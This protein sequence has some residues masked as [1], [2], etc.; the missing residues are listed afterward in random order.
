MRFFSLLLAL[1]LSL[2]PLGALPLAAGPCILPVAGEEPMSEVER[3]QPYRLASNPITLPGYDGLLLRPYNRPEKLHFYEIAGTTYQARARPA[4]GS[5]IIDKDIR[6]VTG[7]DHFLAG[8][9]GRVLWQLPAGSDQWQEARP[10]EKWWGTAYD[11][12]TGDFYVGFAAQA[13]LLRWNGDAFVPTGPMPTASGAV[14]SPLTEFGL[15][16]AILTLPQ[17]GGTFA[18]AVDWHDEDRRSLWFRPLGGTWTLVATQQDLNRLTPGLRFPGP[19]RD[20]DVSEDGQTVRLFSNHQKDASVLLRHGPDGWTL[21]EAAPY[22]GWVKHRGSGI[23]LAWSGELSQDL[24]ERVLLFFER[25]VPFKP[26]VLQAL[27]PGT[28]VPRPVTEVTPK[29]DV[30]EKT[31]LNRSSIV[32]VP[33]V[34]PLLVEAETGWMAFEGKG[35]RTLPGWE[36][37][38]I[39]ENARISRVGPLVLIQS[40]N[41]VFRVTDTLDA[42]LVQTFPEGTSL[43]ATTSITWLEEA[44]LFVVMAA[45][46][47]AV[48]TSRDF[49]SFDRVPSPVPITSAVAALPDRPGMLLVG[50][51]GLYTLEAECPRGG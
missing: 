32:E 50:T 43:S 23:R 15:P 19:F 12:G 42:E 2:I 21:E 46:D 18:V 47:H 37:N 9:D 8:W 39:G 4:P 1:L 3:E 14:P 20:A 22:Q 48:F 38:R 25:S 16:V 17:A 6:L 7:G 31:A 10:G 51:D 27:D 28:L 45:N 41:G 5:N 13:P 24:T 26:P 33:G 35:F 36:A 44:A 34:E 11:E 29:V 49:V 40:L 30:G